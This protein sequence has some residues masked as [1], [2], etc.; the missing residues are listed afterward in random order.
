MQNDKFLVKNGVDRG[1][2]SS[3][4]LGTVNFKSCY[5]EALYRKWVTVTASCKSLTRLWEAECRS[6][7]SSIQWATAARHVIFYVSP[8]AQIFTKKFT[9]MM[10]QAGE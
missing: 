2:S 4:R 8:G 1:A 6:W 9:V 5:H 7:T 3:I 10:P